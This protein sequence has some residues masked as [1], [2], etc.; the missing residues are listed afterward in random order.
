MSN[1]KVDKWPEFEYLME[2][3]ELEDLLFIRNPL[4]EREANGGASKESVEAWRM[5]VI[6]KL[7]TLKKLDGEVITDDER[8]KASAA[9]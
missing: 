3:P 1:N 8:E 7:P 6:R 4:W 5:Q 9:D 2:L